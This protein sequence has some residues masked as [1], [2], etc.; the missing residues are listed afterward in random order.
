MSD[1][2]TLRAQKGRE[3]GSAASRRI[4]KQGDVPAVVYGADLAEPV[5]ITVNRRELRSALTTEA[6]TNA[7]INLDI[8]GSEHLTLARQIEKHPYRTEIRH[9]DFVTV[10]LTDTIVTDVV[11]DFVG[12]PIAVEEGGVLSTPVS[13]VSIEVLAT[14]IPSSIEVDVSELGIHDSVRTSDLPE[15]D[16]VTYLDDPEMTIA[17]IVIPRAAVEEEEAVE[18]EEGAEGEEPAAE[19]EGETPGE[20]A[21]AG[22][23][24]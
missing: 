5:L 19:A 22:S 20:G 9:V 6:G 24:E 7:L 15:I 18:G 8:D 4:R 21:T 17:T 23:S 1:Q 14:K 12:D 3:T 10:S 16:G 2:I 13:S 11:L